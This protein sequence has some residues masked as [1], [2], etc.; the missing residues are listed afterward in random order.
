[1]LINS[2]ELATSRDLKLNVINNIELPQL[3]TLMTLI[4]LSPLHWYVI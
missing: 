2:K 1:M 4:K 3:I